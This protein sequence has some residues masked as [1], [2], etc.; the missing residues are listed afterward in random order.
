MTRWLLAAIIGSMIAALHYGPRLR[1]T[2]ARAQLV[3]PAL[4]RTIAATMLGALLLRAPMPGG[5][6]LR[7]LVAL[8]V[9]SSWMRGGVA[10]SRWPEAARLAASASAG[11]SILLFGDSLRLADRTPAEPVDALSSARAAAAS[12]GAARAMRARACR[13]A[14]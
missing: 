2:A 11:D 4:L 12:V 6:P 5:A 9:S 10:G 3:G 14:C 1:A 7:Q 13:P 8:D